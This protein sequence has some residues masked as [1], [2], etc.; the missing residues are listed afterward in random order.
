MIQTQEHIRKHLKTGDV[1]QFT[2]KTRAQGNSFENTQLG[3]GRVRVLLRNGQI[4]A[5]GLDKGRG[6]H[7][8]GMTDKELESFGLLGFASTM[9]SILHSD[10]E[11]ICHEDLSL[12]IGKSFKVLK[13]L[14]SFMFII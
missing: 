5:Y 1:I 4:I 13:N 9:W 8:G 10:I 14:F 6:H 7:S 12:Y 11:Y 3:N 2:S